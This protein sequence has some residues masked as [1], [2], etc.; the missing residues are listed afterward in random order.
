MNLPNKLTLSR[1]LL[2]VAFLGVMFSQ[3]RGH[4]TLALALFIAG[5][6]TDFLDGQIARRWNLITNF[7]ILMDPLAD[8]IMVCSAFIAFVGLGWMP[9]WMVVI[10][11]ARELA[12]TG[13]RLLA[14]SRNV[15]LAAERY[16]KHKTISQIVAVISILVLAAYPEWGGFG[17]LFG[18]EIVGRPW[19]WWF[20]EASKWVA[21]L[22]TLL[23]GGI[24]LWK[25]R[26]LYLD[27]L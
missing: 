19:A 2:T 7:G 8:K 18:M 14:A 22:L 6:I 17:R 25:N 3:M 20:T 5:G 13:L 21:V 27:D 12:I 4:E 23:S 10:I 11:V 1:F 26:R 24:Y 16:G 9:A 15:V